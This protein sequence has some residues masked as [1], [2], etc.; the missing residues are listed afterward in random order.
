M[1]GNCYMT[2]FITLVCLVLGMGQVFAAWDGISKVE[3]TKDGDTYIIDTEAKLAWYAENHT[4]GDAKLTADL[5]L[6]GKL[7]IPIAAGTG[8]QKYSKNFDGNGHIIKNLYIDGNELFAKNKDYAQNLG[9]VGVLGGGTVKNL[10]LENV[11]IQ[12]STNAGDVMDH[13]KDQPI[14]VGAVVGWMNEV[15]NN[16][17]DACMVTGSIMTT[18]NGQAVGGIVGDAKGGKITNCLSLVEIHTSGNKADVGGI[19]GVIRNAVSEQVEVKYCV[20]AGTGLKNTGKDGSVGAIVGSAQ[21]GKLEV[22][23]AFFEENIKGIG[24]VGEKGEVTGETQKVNLSNKE[25][26]VILLNGEENET[27]PW[28]VGKTTLMLNGYGRDGYRIVFDPNKGTFAGGKPNESLIIKAGQAIVASE[29]NK[30][31]YDGWTF[32]GWAFTNDAVEPAANLG[33]VSATDTL[34]AVWA[35]IY[36]IQFDVTPGKFP[37][38]NVSVKT[39]RVTKGD[40]VTVDGLGSLPTQYCSKY[41][42]GNEGECQTWSYFTGWSLSN[43]SGA[44][45]VD[46]NTVTSS[47][48]L[49]IYAVWENKETYTVTFNA[50]HHGK[51]TV[52][53]VRLESGNTVSKPT[54][55]TADEGYVFKKWCTDEA[56]S[57]EFEFTTEITESIVLYAQWDLKNYTISYELNGAKDKGSTNPETYTIETSTIQL[58]DPTAADGYDFEGWFYDADFTQKATQIIQGSSGDKKLY[59]KNTK[60][61]YKITYLADYNSYGFASD[62]YKEHGVAVKLESNGRFTRDGRVQVGWATEPDGKKV[63]DFNASYTANA[64]VVLYPAW[65]KISYVVTYAAGSCKDV[66]GSVAN[67]KKYHDEVLELPNGG[68]TCKGYIQDGW[69][70]VDG[71]DKVYGLN[72][73]YTANEPVTLYPYWIDDKVTITRYGAVAIYK[74]PGSTGKTIAVINGEY[75]G[76]EELKIPDDIDVD[77][78]VLERKFNV[79]IMSTIMLPFAIDTSKFKGGKIYKFY[80][81]GES[82]KTW[83]VKIRRIYTP[84]VQANIPYFVMPTETDLNFIGPVTLNT[85]VEPQ[86]PEPL[87]TYNKWEYRGVYRYKVFGD[88][89]ADL[90]YVYGFAGEERNNKRVGEFVKAGAEAYIHPLRGYLIN[91]NRALKKAQNG[92]LGGFGSGISRE[93]HVEIV[94]E[95]DNV[96]DSGTFDT[97]TGEIRLNGWFDVKGRRLKAKPTARGNYYHNGKHV[98]VK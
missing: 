33:N 40:F 63:Y 87:E 2:R 74:Y 30:P 86:T 3:P 78:V 83:T 18:G 11:D 25:D 12:A 54:D 64:S 98:I 20:Y 1:K 45:K 93:I 48:N 41:V 60:K 6:D 70:I 94:D 44:E 68:F 39:I 95:N 7:W 26:V 5:D 62:L 13:S 32:K 34:Y 90:G 38:S 72:S 27:K 73:A 71:G 52:S 89:P 56:C 43:E 55:P 79:G 19:I 96:V 42:S 61:I 46:L 16:L 53:Y 88:T 9:F 50:N 21:L 69:S 37:G 81:I 80:T 14:S 8:N 67:Q 58:A 92:S 82:N 35:P 59:A 66:K 49:K 51:T 84:K 77:S 97:V 28:F 10:T 47:E 36:T 75:T 24:T 23:T 31:S 15:D 85:E 57:K 17:V 4:K 65:E 29:V 91:N 76:P 22:Q